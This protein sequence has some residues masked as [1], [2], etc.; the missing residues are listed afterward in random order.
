MSGAVRVFSVTTYHVSEEKAPVFVKS[1][2]V[3]GTTCGSRM[4][5]GGWP[6][7]F[8]VQRFLVFYIYEKEAYESINLRS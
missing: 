3:P 4:Q 8:D 5:P 2:P 1:R 7:P 6:S